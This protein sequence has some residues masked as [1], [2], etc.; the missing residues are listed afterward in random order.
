[1]ARA[2]GAKMQAFLLILQMFPTLLE[3]IVAIE[4]TAATPKVGPAKLQLIKQVV[5]SA[6]ATE[7]FGSKMISQD[8]LLSMIEAITASI[9]VFYNLIGV[10]K[11]S[12]PA[13]V[14]S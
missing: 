10:F 7:Q 13:P 6:S 4:T 3:A 9:V 2:H 5:S 11:T 8:Q 12:P 1:M 14:S